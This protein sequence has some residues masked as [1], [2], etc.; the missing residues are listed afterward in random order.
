MA[1]IED[2]ALGNVYLL[3]SLLILSIRAYPLV[4]FVFKFSGPA[5]LGLVPGHKDVF[6]QVVTKL[7]LLP[8]GC[9]SGI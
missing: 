5:D 8:L 2:P 6:I 3:S 4:D 1:P 9:C 7:N